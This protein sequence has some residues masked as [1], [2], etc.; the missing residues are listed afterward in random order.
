M[1]YPNKSKPH[2]VFSEYTLT[3]VYVAGNILSSDEHNM[4]G[5]LVQYTMGDEDTMAIKV[6][7]SINS[8]TDYGQQ[9]AESASGGAITTTL[10]ERYLSASGNYWI[11]INP[12]KADTIKIS[13]KYNAKIPLTI[14]P[15]TAGVITADV[16]IGWS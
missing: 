8:G 9:V 4:L 5:I 7:S 11:I 1:I 16:I 6:E 3:D 15:D 10:A 14:P 2:P 12:I 13:A